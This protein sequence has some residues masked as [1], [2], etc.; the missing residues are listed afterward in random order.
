MHKTLWAAML[1]A[2]GPSLQQLQ[3]RERCYEAAEH[4]AQ[5]AVDTQCPNS[6]AT[7]SLR[8]HIM[9]QLQQDQEACE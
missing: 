5:V 6:F 4:K 3:A 1:F 8:D 2:C 7:C 9:Y